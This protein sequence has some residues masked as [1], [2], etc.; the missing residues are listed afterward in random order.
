[1][2]LT[3]GEISPEEPTLVRVHNMERCVICCWS[4]CR[5]AGACALR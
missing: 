4:P 5:G 2:A 1:M 3:R